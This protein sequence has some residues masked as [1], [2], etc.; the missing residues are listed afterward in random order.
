MKFLNLDKFTPET[1]R[2]L[3]V[4]GI[5]HPIHGIG[6]GAFI[7]TN[8]AVKHMDANDPAAQL[9]FTVDIILR[10]VPTLKR[11]QL[12]RYTL[13]QLNQIAEF[14]RGEDVDGAEEA[15][16]DRAGK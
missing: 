14:V 1:G 6:V 5:D 8:I 9:N 11:E 3:K 13:L 16:D 10:L 15:A 12:A 7:D 2:V 4:D